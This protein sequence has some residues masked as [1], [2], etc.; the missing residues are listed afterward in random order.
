M[1][2]KIQRLKEKIYF[3]KENLKFSQ[4]PRYLILTSGLALLPIFSRFFNWSYYRKS[5]YLS[6]P[7]ITRS[8]STGRVVNNSETSLKD[9]SSVAGSGSYTVIHHQS[10]IYSRIDLEG[11]TYYCYDE[12]SK[13]IHIQNCRLNKVTF[14]TE[15]KVIER[16][17]GGGDPSRPTPTSSDPS[18]ALQAMS[19]SSN[20]TNSDQSVA[21]SA[22]SNSARP[23]SP[24]HPT[25]PTSPSKKEAFLQATKKY[26]KGCCGTSTPTLNDEGTADLTTADL[27]EER[28]YR[29]KPAYKSEVTSSLSRED[30]NQTDKV[31]PIKKYIGHPTGDHFTFNEKK[32]S[33]TKR[34]GPRTFAFW[35]YL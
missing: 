25:T 5:D 21:R 11:K 22:Q 34:R 13:T 14:S 18:R 4:L 29:H 16:I 20:R 30:L 12:T 27:I 31:S 35:C 10:P 6:V 15:T 24:S 32:N 1:K 23:S 33:S 8:A 7:T 17:R 28:Q 19:I 26:T 9:C 2:N 3:L